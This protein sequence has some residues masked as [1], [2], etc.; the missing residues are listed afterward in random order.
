MSFSIYV[1]ELQRV[2]DE[3][4]CYFFQW[5]LGKE[6]K[7]LV[8]SSRIS[9]VQ[10][11]RAFT[12]HHVRRE[13]LKSLTDVTLTAR[14]LALS[15]LKRKNGSTAKLWISQVVTRRALLEDSKLP[16]PVILPET[17]YL[18]LTIGQ[19]SAQELTLFEFPCIGDDLNVRDHSKK[20]RYTLERL[21]TVV[22][23]CSNPPHFRGV[24][25]PITKLLEPEPP[26]PNKGARDKK[27]DK[28]Y[29]G[30]LH[31]RASEKTTKTT[32]KKRPA[33]EH[34]SS[35][36]PGLKRPD[37]KATVD[38]KTIASEF[39]QKLFD[40]IKHGNCVRCHSKEHLRSS[41]KEPVG[42]WEEKFDKDKEK[43]WL[44][45]LKW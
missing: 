14:F 3:S 26:K 6:T 20:L 40:D 36:P 17:L 10:Q 34:P 11:G 25:T 16:A 38:G 5:I 8:N 27:D 18:E 44:G 39:Q 41:C 29:K 4:R 35:F 2:Y 21:K 31:S 33:H 22:D 9:A 7:E 1:Q 13:I 43:Y 24:K 45:T 23:R 19:M 12:W 30:R 28:D 15:R 32:D 42:K 37:L